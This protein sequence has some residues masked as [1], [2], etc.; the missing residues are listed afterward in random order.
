[1]IRVLFFSVAFYCLGQCLIFSKII[2]VFD[3]SSGLT[4]YLKLFVQEDIER[5]DV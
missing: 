5:C 1:M 3:S 4:V 2:C